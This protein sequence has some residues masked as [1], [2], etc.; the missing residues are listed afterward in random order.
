MTHSIFLDFTL[1][2]APTWFY[3]SAV[4]AVTLFFKFRRVLSL[5]NW[6]LISLFA[7]A[8]GFLLLL[9]E[10]Q[11][12]AAA[13]VA[14]LPKNLWWGYLWLLCGSMYFLVRCLFDLVLVRRPALESNLNRGGMAWLMAAIFV[15]LGA[16]AIR[17]TPGNEPPIG[18]GSAVLEAAQE[19]AAEI[20]TQT[21]GEPLDGRGTRFWVTRGLAG[22]CHLAVIAALIL[23]GLWHFQ[24]LSAG[25]SAAA[26]Y[27]L[28]PYIAFHVAQVHHVWPAAMI[29]L[30]LLAYR[31]PAVAGLLIGAASA[32]SF[33]PALTLPVWL[34]FYSGR[35]R[36]RFVVAL[37]F[38]AAAFLVLTV[39]LLWLDGQ[40]ASN[41]RQ[42]LGLT[43][44]QPW[45]SGAPKSESFWTEAHWAYRIP[46]FI[47]YAAFVIVTAFWPRPKNLAHLMALCAAV[48]I[49]VQFWYADS[50]GIYVLWYLPLL[51]LMVF[52]PN[53][54]ERMAPTSE[55]ENDLVAKMGDYVRAAGGGALRRLRPTSRIDG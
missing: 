49:G 5:R 18:R 9:Q 14:P 19:R 51:L 39:W 3:L 36:V 22:A 1:P 40:L 32:T 53:L 17:N 55:F 16:V 50:G 25:M 29:I 45:K 6:D 24:D 26:L 15:C 4:L 35:G 20:V 38:A 21:A 10:H 8:P 2:N 31:R 27:L 43:E 48:L 33:F 47:A 44:W 12:A 30:A 34:S 54:S 42:T 41:L 11:R 28:L 23:F 13:G 52:R 7:M 46:V 37:V